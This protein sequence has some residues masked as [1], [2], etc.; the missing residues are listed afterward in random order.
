MTAPTLAF[1]GKSEDLEAAMS[2]LATE[3]NL[4]SG[5]R[6]DNIFRDVG[7]LGEWREYSV[8]VD[9]VWRQ[10]RVLYQPGATNPDGA[11]EIEVWFII[12][13]DRILPETNLGARA[14]VQEG[15]TELDRKAP[16]TKLDVKDGRLIRGQR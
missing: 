8:K 7:G 5:Y 10:F 3:G 2:R 1:G 15:L 6:C 4:M 13:L 12:R 16:V 9:D 11:G 14:A